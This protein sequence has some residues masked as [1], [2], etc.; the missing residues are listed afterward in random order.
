MIELVNHPDYYSN[1]APK[2]RHIIAAL[3]IPEVHHD[4]ECLDVIED[5]YFILMSF[6][7][8]EVVTHLWRY[9]KKKGEEY[10]DL[11]KAEWY[12]LRM[13]KRYS[14]STNLEKWTIAAAM[15][16]ELIESEF[17][18]GDRKSAPEYPPAAPR[19]FSTG[20]SLPESKREKAINHARELLKAD[21]KKG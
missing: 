15:V 13:C 9:G 6:H 5:Y 19:E 2:T 11:C 12:L 8:G 4:R 21:F 7:M 17:S 18:N 14:K 3:G 16:R 10:K 20:Q 1:C